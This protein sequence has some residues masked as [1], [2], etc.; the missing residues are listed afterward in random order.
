MVSAEP[1]DVDVD[2]EEVSVKMVNKPMFS[3]NKGKSR[4]GQAALNEPD[5][6]PW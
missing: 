4:E 6:L 5:T 1:I 3:A 2:D